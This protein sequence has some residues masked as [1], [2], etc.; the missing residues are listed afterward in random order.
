MFRYDDD[1][2]KMM[3]RTAVLWL[4]LVFSVGHAFAQGSP[5]QPGNKYAKQVNIDQRLGAQ[6]R[7]DLTFRDESGKTVALG[8]YLGK[9]P[10]ILTLVYYQCPMLCTQVLNGLVKSLKVMKEE[11]GVDFDLL[12]I[13]ID[14]KETPMLAAEKKGAYLTEYERPG[15]SANWHFLTGDETAIRSVA[16]SVGFR[17]LYDSA[18][19][20]YAHA[21]GI[22]VLTPA[23]KVAGYQYTV[24]FAPNELQQTLADA[25]NEKIGKPIQPL[26][27]LCFEYDPLTAKYGFSIRKALQSGS[28]LMAIGIVT[29]VVILKRRERKSRIDDPA[30]LYAMKTGSTMKN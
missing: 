24:E 17:Y 27:W 15:A 3:S 21:A 6:V 29:M 8:E 11:P 18:S 10:V 25:A 13:S 4:L 7:P 12:T 14:P 20:Q 26:I 2:M 22:M 5:P 28:I 30:L 16:D 1:N 9:R 19:G 23:G